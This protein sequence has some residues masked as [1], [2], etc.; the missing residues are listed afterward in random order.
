MKRLAP[1]PLEEGELRSLVARI[2][3]DNIQVTKLILIGVIGLTHRTHDASEKKRL[4]IKYR[5]RFWIVRTEFGYV[6]RVF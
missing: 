6:F 4:K 3:A 5:T 2:I 1:E